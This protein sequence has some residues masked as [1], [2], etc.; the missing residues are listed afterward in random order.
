VAAEHGL[1]QGN[2]EVVGSYLIP[3]VAVPAVMGEHP[4]MWAGISPQYCSNLR[5]RRHDLEPER[6]R[7]VGILGEADLVQ[8]KVVDL[9]YAILAVVLPAGDVVTIELFRSTD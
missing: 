5:R 4:L 3:A 2:V 1:P 8:L 9:A 6:L 7:E